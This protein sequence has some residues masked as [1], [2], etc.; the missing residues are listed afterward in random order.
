[1]SQTVEITAGVIIIDTLKICIIS[2]VEK[3][4]VLPYLIQSYCPFSIL[5]PLMKRRE[6]KNKNEKEDNNEIIILNLYL[7]VSFL[8]QCF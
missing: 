2:Y 5:S 1:M 6:G 7:F 8:F 4:N 3:Y